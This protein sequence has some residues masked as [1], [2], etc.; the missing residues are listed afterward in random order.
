MFHVRA[1][2]KIH[3]MKTKYTMTLKLYFTVNKL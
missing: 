3:T 1:L 2:I